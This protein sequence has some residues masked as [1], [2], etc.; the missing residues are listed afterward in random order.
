MRPGPKSFRG[1]KQAKDAKGT[2]KRL[3]RYIAGASMLRLAVVPLLLLV[4]PAA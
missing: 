1:G 2:M 4:H 3:M